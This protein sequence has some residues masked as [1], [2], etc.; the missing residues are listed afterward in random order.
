[1][2]LYQKVYHY[3]ASGYAR[4]VVPIGVSAEPIPNPWLIVPGVYAYNDIAYDMTSEGLY[5]LFAMDP[6]DAYEDA[7]FRI[8]HAGTGAAR[9]LL[10]GIAA[11]CL[12]GRDHET[13]SHDQLVETARGSYLALR[14]GFV[15]VFART[16]LDQVGIPCRSVSCVTLTDSNGVDDGHVMTEVLTDG[17][18]VLYDLSFDRAF[19]DLDGH[20]LNAGQIASHVAAGTYRDD[21]IVRSG[22][23]YWPSSSIISHLGASVVESAGGVAAWT[24]RIVQAVGILDSDGRYYFKLPTGTSTARKQQLLALSSD[25]RV[26]DNHATWRAKFY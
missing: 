24:R 14:C 13:L 25:Y 26:I 9:P 11:V 21:L 22:C 7:G 18:W 8:S 19:R 15:D 4:E 16:I 5:R 23:A 20:L 17:R 1:M 6:S 12:H 2:A 10:A 3:D